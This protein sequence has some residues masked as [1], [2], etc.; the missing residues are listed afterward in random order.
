MRG[1][2]LWFLSVV[3]L[4]LMIVTHDFRVPFNLSS[5][6]DYTDWTID[7]N[8]YTEIIFHRGQHYEFEF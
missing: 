7:Q 5:R 6:A 3:S 2:H 8:R 4:R 1:Q